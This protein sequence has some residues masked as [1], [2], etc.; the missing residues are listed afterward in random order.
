[1][2]QGSGRFL[3]ENAFLA[4]AVFLPL[5]VVVFFVLASVIPRWLVAPPAYDLLIRATDAYTQV[6]S[7]VSIDFAVREGNVD[8]VVRPIA[9]NGLGTRSRLF[10][11]DHATL[12][13]REVPVEM[14]EQTEDLKESDLPRTRRVAALAGRRVLDQLKAPD[15]YQLE[16]RGSRGVGIVGELFGMHRYGSEMA[17]VNKG[18]VIPIKL[19]AGFQEMYYA[20]IFVG[21]MEPAAAAGP[22]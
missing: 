11:F 1:V 6:V 8:V 3:R 12:S 21:W 18:R 14:P 10:L 13:V 9:A 7:R 2:E 20:P 15:G 5:L 17:L 16:S 22:R 4:A 19:P